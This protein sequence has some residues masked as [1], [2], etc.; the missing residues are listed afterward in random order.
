MISR[1]TVTLHFSAERIATDINQLNF[2]AWKMKESKFI[3]EMQPRLTAASDGLNSWL[4]QTAISVIR[5]NNTSSLSRLL[6]IYATIG[7]ISGSERLVREEIIRP[8][9][10]SCLVEEEAVTS[11][12]LEEVCQALLRI[13]P[14][15]L[16]SLLRLT[17]DTNK[18]VEGRRR[19]LG[20]H[21]TLIGSVFRLRHGVRLPGR[22]LLAG[23]GGEFP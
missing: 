5:D 3:C 17:T 6:R 15:H 13:I 1:V 18:L 21:L 22:V 8:A 19:Q 10:E 4:D 11:R 7:R 20:P 16:S 2:T 9:V 23:G 12:R 14:E